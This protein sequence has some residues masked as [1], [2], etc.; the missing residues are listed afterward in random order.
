[1]L[2]ERSYSAQ[3]TAH[4]LLGIPLVRCSRGFVNLTLSSTGS[5][6]EVVLD[7][8]DDPVDYEGDTV[9]VPVEACRSVTRDS[10]LER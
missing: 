6:R 3:E 7:R 4:L 10:W 2:S 8:S 5:I 9:M 1:M